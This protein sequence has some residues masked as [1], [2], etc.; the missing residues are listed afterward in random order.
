LLRAFVVGVLDR[1]N[2]L[3]RLAAIAAALALPVTLAPMSSAQQPTCSGW[4]IEYALSASLELSETPLGQY[5]GV[6]AIGPGRA[7]LRL[8]DADGRPGGTT[9]MLSYEMSEDFTVNSKLAVFATTVVT[10]AR[11][12]ATPDSSGIAARGRLEGTTLEWS[13][14]VEG[15][16]ADGTLTCEGMLCGKLGTPPPGRSEFHVAPHPVRLQPFEFTR[17]LRAFTMASTFVAE[18]D[19]PRQTVYIALV[20]TETYRSCM[21]ASR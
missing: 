11:S 6:Y 9:A 21:S 13:T 8:E 17:D 12:C 2:P 7:V 20:G 1:V 14:P 4:Q 18:T 5:D 16:R 10:D 19:V 15:Y 3:R